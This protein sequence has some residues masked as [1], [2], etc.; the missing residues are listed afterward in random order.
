MIRKNITGLLVVILMALIMF[1]SGCVEE[2]PIKVEEHTPTTVPTPTSTLIQIPTPAPTPTPNEVWPKY[3]MKY[4][5]YD[6]EIEYFTGRKETNYCILSSSHCITDNTCTF[7]HK[8]FRVTEYTGVKKVDKIKKYTEVTQIITKEEYEYYNDMIKE[9]I[10]PSYMYELRDL[11]S[12]HILYEPIPIVIDE[13]MQKIV[14]FLSEEKTDE[15][16]YTQQA[17]ENNIYSTKYLSRNAIQY[18]LSIG[19]ILL[20]DSQIISQSDIYALN[21]FYL[22]NQIYF[23]N[24]T[25]D[26]IMTVCEIFDYGYGYGKLYPDESKLSLFR[27][28]RPIRHDLNISEICEQQRG[29][30]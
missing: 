16:V 19:I 24:P 25:T 18:N 5:C 26:E 12:L 2:A 30:I 7:F 15:M 10:G 29:F 27:S 22:D 6:I 11:I 20:S 13:S 1:F 28:S 14:D 21:Y 3:I 8:D 9:G 23:I 4:N 17:N